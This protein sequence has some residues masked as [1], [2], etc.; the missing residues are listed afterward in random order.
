M[1]GLPNFLKQHNPGKSKACQLTLEKKNKQGV[2]QR[3]QPCLQSFFTKCPKNLVPPTVP[4][5]H[6]MITHVIEPTSS[7]TNVSALSPK[8]NTLVNKLLT[9]LEKVISNLPG[10][11]NQTET[12]GLPILPHILPTNTNIYD[13]LVF[14]LDPHLNHFLGFGKSVKSIAKLLKGQKKVLV[15]MVYFL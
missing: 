11:P 3:T 6:C 13:A 14:I 5:P 12:E 4:A 8:P 9:D 1:G 2:I 7:I 15:S 10:H